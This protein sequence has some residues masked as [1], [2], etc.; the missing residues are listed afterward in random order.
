MKRFAIVIPV[1]LLSLCG[2]AQGIEFEIDA[3]YLHT[4]D[5]TESRSAS[6]TFTFSQPINDSMA[7]EATW[8]FTRHQEFEYNAGP[9]FELSGLVNIPV[10][11]VFSVKAGLGVNYQSVRV[12]WTSETLNP[13]VITV[14]TISYSSSGTDGFLCDVYEN[15]SSDVGPIDPGA[16]YTF[17]NLVIPIS[18]NA[19][20][21]HERLNVG[22]GI[23]FQTPVKA[24]SVQEVLLLKSEEIDGLIHCTYETETR[25]HNP[26]ARIRNAQLGVTANIGYMFSKRFGVVVGIRKMVTGTFSESTGLY[27]QLPDDKPGYKPLQMNAGL[28]FKF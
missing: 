23:N 12:T 15:S 9:G 25:R 24:K 6:E 11:D 10:S 2:I 14:D 19:S 16:N 20:L 17:I 28:T 22:A 8:S 21:L 27:D 26:A 7:L 3:R 13:T 1:L 4:F 5:Q 18:L